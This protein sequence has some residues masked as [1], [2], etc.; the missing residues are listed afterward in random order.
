MFSAYHIAYANYCDGGSWTGDSEY[1]S[2]TYTIYYHG[3]QLLD[4]L[5]YTL[6]DMGMTSATEIIYSGCS[7]GALTV[8]IHLDHVRQLITDQNPT[9]KVVGLSDSMYTMYYNASITRKGW[10]SYANR[11]E[12]GYTAWNASYALN[13]DCIASFYTSQQWQCMLAENIVPL[14]QTPLFIIESKYD[15]WQSDAILGLQ[16]Y[17][18][19]C[20]G[21]FHDTLV[22][23]GQ[24]KLESLASLPKHIGVFLTNCPGHCATAFEEYATMR[25]NNNTLSN[26]VLTWYETTMSYYHIGLGDFQTNTSVLV[27]PKIM[28]T[29]NSY[30]CEWDTC[31]IST[32]HNLY[33]MY[34]IILSVAILVLL[35]VILWRYI[36]QPNF[37]IITPK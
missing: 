36:S 18:N 19:S 3:Q 34:T 17:I 8:F 10:T 22:K 27:A 4:T 16:C 1:S 7:A 11:L 26:T 35:C 14:I 37:R 21:V 33:V 20:T 32:Q 25:V 24:S 28:S 12:W 2:D 23:F 29:C 15:L 13:K 5:I 9:A 6:L 30:P 31:G